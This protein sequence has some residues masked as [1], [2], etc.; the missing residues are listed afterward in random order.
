MGRI[1]APHGGHG[2][3]FLTDLS[4]F[5]SAPIRVYSRW[6]PKAD[7][8]DGEPGCDRIASFVTADA[9]ADKAMAKLNQIYKHL[10]SLGDACVDQAMAQA[11]PTA[12]ADALGIM[13][14]ILLQRRQIQGTIALVEQYH[15]LP[16]PIRH[17]VL[18]HAPELTR[19]LRVVMD[20]KKTTGPANAVHIIRQSALVRQAYLIADQLR[21]G[22]DDL[23]DES[24]RCL[25]EMA[26]HT[27]GGPDQAN[28]TAWDPVE[29]TF[30]RSAIHEAIKFYA[31]HSR[32]DVL[33]AMFSLPLPAVTELLASLGA[34]GAPLRHQTGVL[35]T[36]SDTSAVRRSLLQALVIHD[37]QPF[38]ID[39]LRLS[40]DAGTFGQAL[41]NWH[42]L[43]LKR[44]RTAL[45]RIKTADSYIP[46]PD[47]Y[48]KPTIAK[49]A[50]GL[51]TWITELPQDRPKQVRLLA[52]INKAADPGTR[53]GALRKLLI[54]AE[55]APPDAAVHTAI[56]GFCADP[57]EY[58]IR[59]ALTHLIRCNYPDTAR[60][61]AQLVNSPHKEIQRIAGKR[62]VPVAFSRLWDSWHRLNHTQRIGAGRALIKID[63]GFHT[64]LQDKLNLADSKPKL[65]A[66]SI[67]GELNQGMLFQDT[68]LRL[69]RDRDPHVV[70]AA[71]K[72]LGTAEPKRAASAIESALDHEDDRVRA[73]AVEALARLDST[74]HIDQIAEMTGEH[75]PNRARANA[76][77]AL[78]QMRAA[79]AL[80]ALTRMLGDPRP[81]HRTSALWLVESMGIA[82]VA[83]EVAE[84]SISEPDL[85]VRERAERVIL[86]VIDQMSQPLPIHSL[87]PHDPTNEETSQED[88]AAA[89]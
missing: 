88:H 33:R 31:Q 77:Q 80:H 44:Y 24:A 8:S 7:N 52:G 61:L 29:T 50:R 4:V 87:V 86:Q 18:Q 48:R 78:M 38:A 20:N 84:M 6:A 83:R 71:V 9:P 36:R 1:I 5:F 68:I 67:I 76:I 27:A 64:A 82:E 37:L 34:T 55:K 74:R 59:V 85:Q 40:I 72:A 26:E 66:L 30:V 3:S 47:F 25:L 12:D 42:L 79:D 35:L 10:Q 39:G 73:N 41:E 43:L 28:D 58:I 51:P 11:L 60:V 81:Q 17:T 14:L 57:S 22:H 16:E 49:Q 2:K 21:Q 32:Q 23:K 56:A 70:S 62:L 75:E 89:G 45:K 54:L 69:C 19:A 65:R 15:R 63:P 46:S 13:A 53:L